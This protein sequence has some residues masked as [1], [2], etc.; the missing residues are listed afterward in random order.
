MSTKLEQIRSLQNARAPLTNP[1]SNKGHCVGYIRVST[2]EQ[3]DEGHS[4]DQ[5]RTSIETYA[6]KNNLIVDKIY[7]DEGISGSS[8]QRPGLLSLLSELKF[9]TIVIC[10]ETDRLSRDLRYLLELKDSIHSKH[11]HIVFINRNLDTSK[12]EHEMIIK[13][14]AATD[15]EERN[16]IRRRIINVMNDMSE[17]GTLKRKPKFGFMYQDHVLVE[18]PEEMLIVEHI[19]DLITSEP[20]ITVSRICRNLEKEGISIRKSARIYATTITNIISN[21]NLRSQNI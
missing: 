11:S 7:S 1:I 17:K 5:Q 10:T 4:L 8:N 3:R 9:F 15:E 21:H 20:K 18:N 16:R 19:R 6:Q 2:D 14:Y 12:P 13:I